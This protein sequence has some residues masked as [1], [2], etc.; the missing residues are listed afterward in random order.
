MAV[1]Q[2]LTKQISFL[3]FFLILIFSG[4]ANAEPAPEFFI[5]SLANQRFESKK[6]KGPYVVSFFFVDCLPCRKEI[7]QLYKMMTQDYPKVSLLFIDP[8]K[9]DSVK[10]IKRFAR[11]LKV[12]KEYFYKDSFGAVGNKF[13]MDKRGYPTI[14]GINGSKYLFVVNDLEIDSIN[15]I[16][17]MLTTF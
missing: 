5:S 4:A 11:K 1:Y 17:E 13:S 3:P 15:K 14:F 7:P 10:K 8:I 2:R 12:P 9:E 16:K 6:V